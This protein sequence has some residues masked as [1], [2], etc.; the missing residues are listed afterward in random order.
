MKRDQKA[1]VPSVTRKQIVAIAIVAIA[2]AVIASG[3]AWWDGRRV[4][5]DPDTV[6]VYKDPSCDC[7]GRWIRHLEQAGFK[8]EVQAE[9]DLGARNAQLGIPKAL[10]ACHTAIV[11]GYLIE[12]HVP[13]SDI[14]RLLSERPN[15]RGLAVPGMP[16]GSPGM[17]TG[18]Q[19]DPYDVVL[20]DEAGKQRVF[21][22]YGGESSST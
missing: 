17:E 11:H 3:L 10:A 4:A 13:A 14:R 21:S 19:N 5:Y 2:C 8:V 12:G 16:V 18:D 9:L 15:A 7:C 6:V 20:F 22:H 1:P